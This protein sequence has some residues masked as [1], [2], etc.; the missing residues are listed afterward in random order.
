MRRLLYIYNEL[1]DAK[2]CFMLP[3]F[4]RL[5]RA[6]G[7]QFAAKIENEPVTALSFQIG[8]CVIEVVC[9]AHTHRT[10]EVRDLQKSDSGRNY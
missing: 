1:D 3:R 9:E 5:N 6:R 2:L 10:R 7:A 4:S 8:Y